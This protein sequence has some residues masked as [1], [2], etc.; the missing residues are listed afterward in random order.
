MRALINGKEE[1]VVVRVQ[2]EHCREHGIWISRYPNV[3]TPIS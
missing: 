1:S 2:W 3:G